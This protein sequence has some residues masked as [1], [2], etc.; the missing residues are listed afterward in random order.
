[1]TT[2]ERKVRKVD[3]R[4][5]AALD[6][7]PELATDGNLAANVWRLA[8]AAPNDPLAGIGLGWQDQ[9]ASTDFL[10]GIVF[11]V[12]EALTDDPESEPDF[13]EIADSAVPTYN[14][15]RLAAYR[16][17]D[18]HGQKEIDPEGFG[19]SSA[20]TVT[21]VIGRLMYGWA[22]TIASALWSAIEIEEPEE[23]E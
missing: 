23:T 3:P 10:T 12:E 14:A 9:E 11:A 7:D 20:D 21:E 15:E 13:A 8:Y 18:P 17:L 5:L 4:I 22:E 2:T 19:V 1:M 6:L 16:E